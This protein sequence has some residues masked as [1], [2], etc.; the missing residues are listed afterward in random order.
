MTD[1]NQGKLSLAYTSIAVGVVIIVLGVPLWWV[2]TEVYRAPLP[3]NRIAQLAFLQP[4]SVVPVEVVWLTKGEG[5]TEESTKLS[6]LLKAN[7]KSASS[8]NMTI[9]DYIITTRVGNEMEM[10]IVKENL[11]ALNELDRKLG[12]LNPESQGF[13]F[14]LLRP[15]QIKSPINRIYVGSYYSTFIV[16]NDGERYESFATKIQ[17]VVKDIYVNEKVLRN[18]V[19]SIL[20]FREK[21][22]DVESM[23]AIRST[24]SYQ[25]SFTLINPEPHNLIAKWKIADAI[26]IY[27]DPFLKALKDF[28]SF[29]IDSQV[30]YYSGLSIRPSQDS[31]TG[32]YYLTP[33][34]LPRVINSIESRL[35]SHATNNPA[36]NFILYV[37]ETKFKNLH[38][39]T[40]KNDSRMT[41]SFI[42]PRWGGFI[43]DSKAHNALNTSK[44]YEVDLK[45][46]MDIFVA[47]LKLLLG[48]PKISMSGD[49]RLEFG[50]SDVGL[51]KWEY[52]CLLRRRT[53]ENVASANQTLTSLAKLLEEITNIVISDRIKELINLSIEELHK[54]LD[55]MK[56]G[57]NARAFAHSKTAV[58]N[59]E[60]AFFDASLLEL[61]YFPSDQ[62]FAVYVP[63]FLP[64]SLPILQSLY[65]AIR[66]LYRQR[67]DKQK[68]E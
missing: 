17:L 37:P 43:I 40:S 19:T 8:D 2:T 22:A 41:Y 31:A 27:L 3:Y 20:G 53:L 60:K 36:A 1:D 57:D 34:L 54:S 10:E 15:S 48:I 39:R 9:I 13:R 24:D 23:R 65:H 26:R 35:G 32:S 51:S 16:L 18:T 58:T 28:S 21:K 14:Y 45:E 62:K 46:A 68:K 30:L 11:I 6:E 33:R 44:V 59:S 56:S 42:S 25:L 49:K 55:F 12:A 38:I 67:K 64:I 7:L 50:K 52:S 4:Q 47:H 66:F 61:L 29:T 5:V 63:L